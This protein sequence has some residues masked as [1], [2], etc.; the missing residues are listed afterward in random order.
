[1]E[2]VAG[3]DGGLKQDFRLEA[4]DVRSNSLRVNVSSISNEL[5]LFRIPVSELLPATHFYLTAYA[6][7]AKGKSEVALLE[8]IILRDSG[9]PAGEFFF[10]S[11]KSPQISCRY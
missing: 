8:D 10:S 1:M 6:V 7:N 4:Y 5:P 9:K 3:Y 2:C 11:Q